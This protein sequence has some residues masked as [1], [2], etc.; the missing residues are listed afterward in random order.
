M[1]AFQRRSGGC[2]CGFSTLNGVGEGGEKCSRSR[3][4]AVLDDER[5]VAGKR[6]YFPAVVVVVM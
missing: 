1:S 6:T 4:G 5:K 2:C 3:F